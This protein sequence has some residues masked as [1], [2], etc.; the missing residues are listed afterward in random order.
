MKRIYYKELL[1][2]RLARFIL[3]ALFATPF[4]LISC[5]DDE[6]SPSSPITI[7]SVTPD[8]GMPG[9]AVTIA[10][11]GFSSDKTSV[12]VL[13]N[14]SP[15]EI[16][17]A[18]ET[19]LVV[20]VPS[21]AS[22]GSIDIFVGKQ[23]AVSPLFTVPVPLA[24]KKLSVSSAPPQVNIR[25]SGV[26]F[27][28]KA[29]ENVVKFNGVAAQVIQAIDTALVVNVPTNATSGLITIEAYGSKVTTGEFTVLPPVSITSISPS[30][31]PKGTE[32]T[33]QGMSF[34]TTPSMNIVRINGKSAS[35]K[36]A[37]ATQ[38]VVLVPDDAGTGAVSITRDSVTVSQGTFVYQY[39]SKTTTFAGSTLG[40]DDGNAASAQFNEPSD[41]A[42]DAA[43]NIYVADEQNNLIRKITSAGSVTTLAGSVAGHADGKG[44][45]AKFNGPSALVTDSAGNLFVAE[46]A[47]YIRKITPDGT[48][49]TLAGDG[50]QGHKDGTAAI[51]GEPNGIAIDSKS[52]LYV[53]EAAGYVRKIKPSGEVTT[54]AGDGT[55]GY[56]DGNGIDAKFNMP[57]GIGINPGDDQIYVADAG[58]NR[59]R[60][61]SIKTG[62]V[63]TFAGD[64]SAGSVDDEGTAARFNHPEGITVDASGR[65]FV[66]DTGNQRIRVVSANGYVNTIA[67]SGIAGRQNGTTNMSQ[68][69]SPAGL[70]ADGSGTLY[71]AD[72]ANALIRIITVE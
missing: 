51:F 21:G 60:V 23:R 20:T 12:R 16:T 66:S 19:Q 58:N 63:K 68:F 25:V 5:K 36:S 34:G 67:G 52:N 24:F 9:T 50:T 54:L 2:T 33:V 26:G 64:G 27:S 30:T 22:T 44:D 3:I 15:G 18:S 10:G 13:F 72:R 37:T 62:I 7:S 53:T 32:V 49:T 8:V 39:F 45:K 11:L 41:L 65:V 35:V 56:A 43:G 71:V 57:I 55:A 17:S 6:E 31:G 38:L 14:G 59:I 42:R 61:I 40:R 46:R 4:V 47:G 28:K 70:V 29:G 48:V 69:N 1:S